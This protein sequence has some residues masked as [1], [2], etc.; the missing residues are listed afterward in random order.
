MLNWPDI[1]I[2][3]RKL[4]LARHLLLRW[5]A[6]IALN[7]S[8]WLLDNAFGDFKILATLIL[9]DGTILK[10]KY[11]DKLIIVTCQDVNFQIYPLAFGIVNSE[12][13]LSMRW[14]FTKLR[15][16]IGEVKDLTFVTDRGPSLINGIFEVFPGV[17]HGYSMYHIQGNLKTKYRGKDIISLFRRTT[18][19]YSVEECNKFMV[20]IRSKSFQAQEYLTKM[21]IEH[22]ARLYFSRRRYNRMT[23]NIA[24]SLDVLFKRYRQLLILA[25]I[26][27]IRI[28]LQQWFHDQRAKS[29]SCTSV[30][31]P[32]QKEKLFKDVNVAR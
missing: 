16:A 12:N 8:S 17:R 31:A 6:R 25:P 1:A 20:K 10:S 5:R 2:I 23:S 26:V 19:A 11:H 15:K 3:W 27:N 14:F 4:I 18:E 9:V 22:W 7:S 24:E 21:E 28:K 13:D 30:L 29:Q 32:V